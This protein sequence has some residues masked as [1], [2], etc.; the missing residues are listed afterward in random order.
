MQPAQ[1]ETMPFGLRRQPGE[2]RDEL[3]ARAAERIATMLHGQSLREHVHFRVKHLPH[4]Q[5]KCLQRVLPELPV[6]TGSNSQMLF[7]NLSELLNL[8][9]A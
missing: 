4:R 9:V 5:G 2:D 7:G 1:L 8:L 3:R 6:R